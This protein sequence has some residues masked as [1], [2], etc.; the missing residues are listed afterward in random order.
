MINYTKLANAVRFLSV[1]MIEKAKSGHPGLPLGMADVVTV[2]FSDFINFYPDDPKWPNR[3]RFILSAGHASALLYSLLYLT[4]Y[5]NV[6]VD[7]LKRFRQ[8]GSKTT[9][10]PEYDLSSGIEMTTGPLGQ[11]ISTAV[12]IAL[13]QELLN[14]RFRKGKLDYHIYVLSSDGDMM[15]GLTQEAISLAGHLNL[16]KLIVLYDDNKITID[17]KTSLSM[18]ENITERFEACGWHVQTING[19]CTN[20]IKKAIKTAKETKKPSLIR[21]ETVIGKGAP[22]KE[23]TSS[24]HGAP[25]G[26]DTVKAMRENLNWPDEPFKIPDDILKKWRDIGQKCNGAYE[27]WNKDYEKWPKYDEELLL[28]RYDISLDLSDFKR[29]L[30]EEK[31]NSTRCLS[32]KVLEKVTEHIPNIIGGSADLTPSN[33]TKTSH[34]IPISKEN[35]NGNYIHYGIREHAMAAIMNGLNL[36]NSFISYG[37]TFLVFSDYLKPAIRMSAMMKQGVIYVFTHDSIGVGEDGPTHQ[38]VEHL[39]SLRSIP[40]LNVMRPCDAVEVFECWKIALQSRTTPT[41]LILT[42]QNVS[43]IR[44]YHSNKNLC[45]YGGYVVAESSSKHDVTLIATGSEVSL[46]INV[47]EKL[48]KDGINTAVV[49]LPSWYLFD[50]QNIAYKNEVLGKNTLRVAIEAASSFGWH[51]YVGEDGLF[52]GIDQFGRS[53]SAD[54]L[55]DFFGLNVDTIINKIKEKIK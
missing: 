48:D 15:E 23:G 9:G 35:F 24:V 17:G 12:G 8:F 20:S 52:I 27:L 38:P 16:S 41:A 45:S 49:S 6:T 37:G 54:D 22:L 28:G 5:K 55:F 13:S 21:C 32:Q 33:N 50:K 11:G 47:K 53:G 40:N 34:Y 29:Q 2:L 51:R 31:E 7:E 39:A 43:K 30:L 10:H 1:D 25:L 19:H 14:A 4:G 3:D 46:A 26:S 42:R 18:S 36:S 44:T